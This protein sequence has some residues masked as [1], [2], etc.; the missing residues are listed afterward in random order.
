MPGRIEDYA[1]VGDLLTAALVGRDGSLDW[2]CLPRFD[3]PACFAALLGDENNGRWMIAPPDADTDEGVTVR[4]RYRG[5]SLVLETEWETATGRATVVDFMPRR[6]GAPSVVRIVEG[7]SGTVDLRM[8]LRLRF[9]YGSVVPWMHRVDGQLTGIAGPESV[10]LT[11]PVALTGQGETH[12][13]DFT[14]TAGERIPSV[15]TWQPSHLPA[16]DPVDPFDA[17]RR[18]EE[19]WKQWLRPFSYDGTYRDAVVRSLITLKA[20]T[21]EPTGGIV[22]APTTSLPEEPG[23][24][25]NW[26]YRYCWLRDAGMTLEALLRSGF[27]A[28]AQAWRGWLER[29]VAGRPNDIQIMYGIGGERRLTEWTADWLAGYENSRPVRIGN[30]A[31][32][33]QQLDVPGEL[34]ETLALTLRCGLRP[35]RHLL[36]LQQTLLDHLEEVWTRPDQGLWETRGEPRHHVHSK[37]MCWVA[38][39]RAVR[40]AEEHGRPGPVAHWREVRDRIHREV[41]ERGFDPARA[42]FTQSYGS[43][44]LD[45]ALLLIPGTGFLPPDDPRVIGTVAAVEREL[46]TDDGLV[47]RYSTGP[48]GAGGTGGAEAPD[49][50]TGGEGAF[51]ACSFW[52]ADALLLTGREDDARRLFERLLL[53]RNDLGLLAEEYDPLARRQ[54]G[55]FPQAFTHVPL[56]R[57]AYELDGHATHHGRKLVP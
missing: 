18:T 20:L 36:S 55:N 30:G 7:H 5:D 4:R 48:G 50:L 15:L 25:R 52:L 46:A 12:T 9:E 49:G 33:Q 21:Y 40:L 45:A 26:D 3:S 28:E 2:L 6:D 51:L 10:W 16:P 24:V 43:R 54:L 32:A 27:T 23:G 37:V 57:V 41:C 17:L 42:T 19:Y 1:L 35:E 47:S 22:A 13:A 44:A 34:M 14:V 56:I 11:T 39:D 29:A 53:L 31:A 38:F 8:D